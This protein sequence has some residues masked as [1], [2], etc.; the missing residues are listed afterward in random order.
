MKNL[1]RLISA[2][3]RFAIVAPLI[4][5]WATIAATSTAEAQTIVDGGVDVTEDGVVNS[6][7]DAADVLLL[8]DEAAPI[9]V[10][11]ID[12]RVDVTESGVVSTFDDLVNV[13]LNDEAASTVGRNQVDI[14]NGRIDVNESG[15][16]TSADD[17]NNARFIAPALPIP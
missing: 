7:D 1:R 8:F 10:D 11:I 9:R 2:P 15:A 5:G 14:I 16:I 3:L 12:G 13:D 4:F 17:V 6:S